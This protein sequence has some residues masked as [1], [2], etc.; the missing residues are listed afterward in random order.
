[1][2][3]I[4]KGTL[5]MKFLAQ[6]VA[7]TATIATLYYVLSLITRY[8][9]SVAIPGF[10]ISFE[11]FIASIFGVKITQHFVMQRGIINAR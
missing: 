1:M 9:S 10:K 8:V 11:A 7:L 4:T 6:N 3:Y 5:E 2:K